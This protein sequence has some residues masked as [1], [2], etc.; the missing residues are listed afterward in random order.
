MGVI[1]SLTQEE[2]IHDWVRL[3]SKI[4]SKIDLTEYGIFALYALIG[5]FQVDF[6]RLADW[7]IFCEILIHV[8][9]LMATVS[10]GILAICL[11]SFVFFLNISDS[12]F[13]KKIAVTEIPVEAKKFKYINHSITYLKHSVLSFI[14][15]IIYPLFLVGYAL[16]VGVCIH[17]GNLLGLRSRDLEIVFYVYMFNFLLLQLIFVLILLRLRDLIFNQTH[18]VMAMIRLRLSK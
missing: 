6:F 12:E 1:E 2:S 8:I 14:E 4:A 10:A 16:L 9:D 15:S 3:R 18:V 11:A 17:I 7:R 13:I 5:L